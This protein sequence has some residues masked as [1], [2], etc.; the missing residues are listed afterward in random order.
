MSEIGLLVGA[1]ILGILANFVGCLASASKSAGG[2]VNPIKWIKKRPYRVAMAVI[3]AVAG[4]IVLF[5]TGQL[6]AVAAFASGY[7]GSDVVDKIAD[8]SE[9][10]FNGG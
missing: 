8:A 7:L 9:N 6:T 5:T 1:L 4:F 2:P 3:G 10:R